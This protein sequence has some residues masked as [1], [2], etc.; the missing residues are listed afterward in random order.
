ML[1]SE[2]DS[3]SV[4][5]ESPG[6]RTL[7][8]ALRTRADRDPHGTAFSFLVNEQVE[9]L[10]VSYATLDLRA[11]AIAVQL[12]ANA[13]PGDRALLLYPPGPEYVANFFGCLYA[14]V[15]AIP[16]Y[17]PEAGRLRV[18]LPR[19]NSIAESARPKVV[20]APE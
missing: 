11:R 5:Q 8:D 2:S 16:A 13:S 17:A 19:L 9:E 1:R 12:A 18:T 20:L 14:G 15:V 3:M 7:V 4:A 6:P 10:D